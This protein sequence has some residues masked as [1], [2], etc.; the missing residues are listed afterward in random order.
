[1]DT[2]LRGLE[3][4]HGGTSLPRIV[5]RAIRA[6]DREMAGHPFD[7]P[8]LHPGTHAGHLRP[9]LMGLS[10]RH[11]R[12]LDRLGL[13]D[14]EDRQ[15][16]GIGLV[17]RGCGFIDYFAHLQQ[18]RCRVSAATRSSLGAGKSQ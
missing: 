1:M 2:T 11:L 17:S 16:V 3:R 9:E 18:S 14:A 15:F 6:T 7:S 8:G 13:V 5:S 12:V 10:A 4:L